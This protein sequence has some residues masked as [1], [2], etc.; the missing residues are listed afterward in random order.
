LKI[1]PSNSLNALM[2]NRILKIVDSVGRGD[3]LEELSAA[4]GATRPLCTTRIAASRSPTSCAL[5]MRPP[6]RIAAYD[7]VI[8]DGLRD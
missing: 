6:E 8:A 1:D 4:Y 2:R 5:C 7:R 3:I